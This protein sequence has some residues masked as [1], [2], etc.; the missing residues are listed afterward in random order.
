MKGVRVSGDGDVKEAYLV[1]GFQF[2]GEFD[3][4]MFRVQVIKE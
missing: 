4:R 1:L 2:I 3:I